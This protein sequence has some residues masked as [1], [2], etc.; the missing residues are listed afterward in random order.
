MAACEF[1]TDVNIFYAII[2]VGLEGH[3]AHPIVILIT[4]LRARY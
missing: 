1:E 3:M 4:K 2:A